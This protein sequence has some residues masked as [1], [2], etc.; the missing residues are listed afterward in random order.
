MI[1]FIITAGS[2]YIR[3]IITAGLLLSLFGSWRF[4]PPAWSN[5]WRWGVPGGMFGSFS[6]KDTHLVLGVGV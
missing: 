1:A 3:Y 6:R 2:F 4:L 5:V